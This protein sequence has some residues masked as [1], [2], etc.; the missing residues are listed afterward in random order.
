MS[1]SLRPLHNLYQ[2][3]SP[4]SHPNLPEPLL[5]LAQLRRRP[6]P[7]SSP[8]EPGEIEWVVAL[9]G[10]G[11]HPEWPPKG[12]KLPPDEWWKAALSESDVTQM[13]MQVKGCAIRPEQMVER[14]KAKW[15]E[16]C[17]DVNEY[18]GPGAEQRKGL[19]LIIHITESL[20][21]KIVLTPCDV[22]PLSLLSI[23]T[24]VIPAYNS[25]S[26]DR[27]ASANAKKEND[28]LRA[29]VSKLEGQLN[30]YKDDSGRSGKRARTNGFM[31]SR[32]NSEGAE[33]GRSGRSGEGASQS[34]SQSRGGASQGYSQ[35][36]RQAS[37]GSA[38][39]SKPVVPGQ[40]HRGALQP[41]DVGYAGNAHR[42]GRV[43]RGLEFDTDSE[44]SE[45]D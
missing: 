19:E 6:P 45:S 9:G 18:E 10:K 37:Q 28:L 20:P 4:T 32:Q 8:L 11:N 31:P 41:G 26:V 38:S 13:L 36:G 17:L 34:Q 44:S 23:L 33:F 15:N 5:V 21:L 27:E 39:P 12:G 29:R 7:K 2:Q 3:I 14:I 43:V 1:L 30:Y 25:C 22:C 42:P 35:G 40:T 24:S 16:G